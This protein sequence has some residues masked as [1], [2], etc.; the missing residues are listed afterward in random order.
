MLEEIISIGG[1][2]LLSGLDSEK[3]C[4][5]LA[6]KVKSQRTRVISNIPDSELKSFMK[7][8]REAAKYAQ[9]RSFGGFWPNY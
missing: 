7:A 6:N 3:F 5:Y 4:E 9:D 2:L 1:I 8:S